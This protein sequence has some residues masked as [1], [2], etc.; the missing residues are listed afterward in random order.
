M[1]LN[2]L[3]FGSSS[4]LAINIMYR[5]D[6]DKVRLDASCK[7]TTYFWEHNKMEM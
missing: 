3:N 5:R 7:L 1:K 4:A 6:L 2:Q